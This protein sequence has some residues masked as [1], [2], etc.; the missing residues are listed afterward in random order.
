MEDYYPSF[1]SA[2][3][4]YSELI[5]TPRVRRRPHTILSG[6]HNTLGVDRVFDSL[7]ELHEN[8]FIP[9]VSSGDLVHQREMRSVLA[10]AISGAVVNQCLDQQVGSSLRVFVISIK[11]EADNMVCSMALVKHRMADVLGT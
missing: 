3:Y 6:S 2:D 11:D 1:I 7:V 5:N 9:V 4:L 8:I 10:P